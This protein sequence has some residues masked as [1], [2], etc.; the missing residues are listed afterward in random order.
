MTAAIDALRGVALIYALSTVL[1]TQRV[2]GVKRAIAGMMSEIPKSICPK[3]K[4]ADQ[5]HNIGR[6]L[7]PSALLCILKRQLALAC[8]QDMPYLRVCYASLP[9]AVAL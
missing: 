3:V 7:R 6:S 4:Y 2:A 8:R 5:F 9:S 1:P